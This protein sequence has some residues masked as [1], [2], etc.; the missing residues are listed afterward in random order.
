MEM[1]IGFWCWEPFW[2]TGYFCRC[3][4]AGRKNCLCSMVGGSKLSVSGMRIVSV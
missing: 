1:G 3:W 2:R 4:S